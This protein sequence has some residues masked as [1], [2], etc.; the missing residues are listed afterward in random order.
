MPG[1]KNQRVLLWGCLLGLA[2]ACSA[3]AAQGEE[4]Y[5]IEPVVAKGSAYLPQSIV[6]GLD[7]EGSRLVALVNGLKTTVCGVWGAKTVV[8][9]ENSPA[10]RGILYGSVKVGALVGIIHFLP[11]SSEDYREDFRD[12]KLRTGYFTMR[13]GQMPDDPKHKD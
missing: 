3:T 2:R 8:G 13:S 9:Q 10:S 4:P 12:Q 5:A 7:P 6:D 1:R 11:E